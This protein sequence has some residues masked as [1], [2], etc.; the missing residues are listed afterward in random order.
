[1][2]NVMKSDYECLTL[3]SVALKDERCYTFKVGHDFK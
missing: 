3:G 1:M 2:T